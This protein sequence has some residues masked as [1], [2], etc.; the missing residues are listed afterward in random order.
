MAA[1]QHNMQI[2]H[3]IALLHY[4]DLMDIGLHLR[5]VREMLPAIHA[6]DHHQTTLESY[7]SQIRPQPGNMIYDDFGLETSYFQ[8]M[9]KQE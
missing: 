6:K 9:N 2:W 3:K 7:Y 8:E 4:G 1:D 5:A